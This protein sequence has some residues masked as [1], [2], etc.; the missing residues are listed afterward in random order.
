MHEFKTQP[1]TA[2]SASVLLTLFFSSAVTK[3][4]NSFNWELFLYDLS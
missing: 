3:Q 2:L 1:I 4:K